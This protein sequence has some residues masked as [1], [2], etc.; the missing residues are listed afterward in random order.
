MPTKNEIKLTISLSDDLLDKMMGAM[1][2]MNSMSSM[3]AL[4][5]MLGGMMAPPT[6]N[7]AIEEK[8]PMGFGSPS[9]EGS[10]SK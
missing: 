9:E 6:S 8:A 4:P 1:I 10:K 7:E 5:M 2:K 3:G